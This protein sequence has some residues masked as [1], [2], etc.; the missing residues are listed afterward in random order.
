VLQEPSPG[1]ETDD[2]IICL[3][4]NLQIIYCVQG[5]FSV[6]VTWDPKIQLSLYR[7]GD[8]AHGLRVFVA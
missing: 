8:F 4:Q 1:K 2:E 7:C 3:G 5:E 6:V